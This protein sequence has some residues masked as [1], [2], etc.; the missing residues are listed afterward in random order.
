MRQLKIINNFTPRDSLSFDKYLREVNK[1]PLLLD[2]EERAI[3]VRIREGDNEALEQLVK[4]NLRFVISV[5]KQYQNQGVPLIDLVNEGN[6]GLLKAGRRFDETK[7]FKFISYAVW[8]IRQAIQQCIYDN[9]RTIR[10][11]INKIGLYQK[12]TKFVLAYE[13][14]HNLLPTDDEIC[15]SLGITQEEYQEYQIANNA[16]FSLDTPVFENEEKSFVEITGDRGAID[17]DAALI[18]QQDKLEIY[19]YVTQLKEKEAK[20]IVMYYGLEDHAAMTLEDIGESLGITRERVRQIKEEAL[21]K[22]RQ[23]AIKKRNER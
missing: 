7:G 19:H 13:Q 3:A 23:M 1:L 6:I 14:E 20:I 17:A 16:V 18:Q 4:A 9:A 11:P 22:M 2:E 10:L 15:E 8:W 12:I 21:N 5:A